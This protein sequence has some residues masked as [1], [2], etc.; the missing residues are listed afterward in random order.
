LALAS[1][2]SLLGA[3]AILDVGGNAVPLN[4]FSA[5]V[6][7]GQ[8]TRQKPPI[9]P[10]SPAVPDLSL[11]RLAASERQSPR[12]K[13]AINVIRVNCPRPIKAKNLFRRQTQVF[14]P[15]AINERAFAIRRGDPHHRWNGIDHVANLTLG[16][17]DRVF[18]RRIHEP[19]CSTF[20]YRL[21]FI[22]SSRENRQQNFPLRSVFF[23]VLMV[24]RRVTGNIVIRRS[25]CPSR[26]ESVSQ[27]PAIL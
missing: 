21:C 20:R 10:I 23:W 27:D 1:A 17:A 13:V 8:R 26:L 4:N 25:L 19:G 14:G 6:T 11:Q 24:S 9:L 18:A 16:A 3:L 7:D 5:L 15:R 22:H 2:F 12:R